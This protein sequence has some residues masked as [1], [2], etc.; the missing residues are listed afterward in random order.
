MF[1]KE[2]ARGR[3]EQPD[4]IPVRRDA[5]KPVIK[6]A[7]EKMFQC[8]GRI[9]HRDQRQG[10]EK[11]FGKTPG[12]RQ[13]WKKA[14]VR[15]KPVKTLISPASKP[16]KPTGRYSYGNR[17][18]KTDIQRPPFAGQGGKP[19]LHK[20]E[21]YGPLLEKKAKIDGRN[22]AG[23]ICVRHRGGAHKRHTA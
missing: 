17:Q 2:H 1:L 21:P 13:D 16:S 19:D 15:L 20:G 6:Q 3:E 12:R 4:R 22:N 9:G 10:K 18:G 14:Y 5:S 7:V 11:K 23:R 8:P